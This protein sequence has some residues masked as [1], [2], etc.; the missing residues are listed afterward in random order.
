MP[1]LQ[2]ALE[3]SPALAVIENQAEQYPFAPIL[4]PCCLVKF[5]SWTVTGQQSQVLIAKPGA[6]KQLV[7]NRVTDLSEYGVHH[8][9]AGRFVVIG[10]QHISIDGKAASGLIDPATKLDIVQ[11]SSI[12]LTKR[13][14]GCVEQLL[15][16]YNLSTISK[17]HPV[18][19]HNIFRCEEHA[20]CS[21]AY[22]DF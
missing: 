3:G 5:E 9:A 4:K 13:F 12:L 21:A 15:D 16:A 18:V 11:H 8:C 22:A 20:C 10:M 6:D 17:T 7:Q 1:I 2:T 19:I 14:R